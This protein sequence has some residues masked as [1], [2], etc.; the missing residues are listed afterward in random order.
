M[1]RIV[2]KSRRFDNTECPI[3]G[4]PLEW[5][6]R[7]RSCKLRE[8]LIC[9]EHCELCEYY[10]NAASIAICS[11]IP[12][13]PA[14]YPEGVERAR[15]LCIKGV[16]FWFIPA[17]A[18]Y[19]VYFPWGEGSG[20][21]E[22]WSEEDVLLAWGS[23]IERVNRR[24]LREIELWHKR[25]RAPDIEIELPSRGFSL[26][27]QTDGAYEIAFR[28][29]EYHGHEVGWGPEYEAG[30]EYRNEPL[31]AWECFRI[32][33]DA[34]MRHGIGRKYPELRKKYGA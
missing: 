26:K 32:R 20:E 7:K 29:Y 5:G 19:A 12:E 2:Y 11:Y 30:R 4:A 9:G 15:G 27:R 25:K 31:D 8:A 22:S 24:I 21:Y 13:I 16:R 3:C 17:L 28:A 1:S 14:E 6:K 18:E 34:Y 10:N 33:L 23:Y